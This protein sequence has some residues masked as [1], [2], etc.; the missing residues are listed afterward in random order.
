MIS[1]TQTNSTASLHENQPA[2]CDFAAYIHTPY[3]N[4]LQSAL[5]HTLMDVA[6]LCF[7]LKVRMPAHEEL[8]KEV[9]YCSPILPAVIAEHLE[10]ALLDSLRKI[11][12]TKTMLQRLSLAREGEFPEF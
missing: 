5:L 1:H 9:A 8:L 7:E 12:K 10:K 3:P 6:D 4:P 11:H 2:S